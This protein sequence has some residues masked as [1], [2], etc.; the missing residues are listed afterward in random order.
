MS[1]ALDSSQP[2]GDSDEARLWAKFIRD[3][4]VSTRN[5]LIEQYLPLCRT[6]AGA[7][8]AKRG[9]LEVEFLD[10]MQFA[11]LGLIEAVQRFDPALGFAFSTYASPRIRGSIL[12]NLEP[13]SEQYTQIAANGSTT[14]G[15]NR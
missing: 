4:D 11:T 12:N 6:I 2:D 8:Y 13:L 1:S 3:R 14:S 7:V 15:W 9:G 10:Y 5:R